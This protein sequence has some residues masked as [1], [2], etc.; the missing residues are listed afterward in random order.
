ML[1][2][3]GGLRPRVRLRLSMGKAHRIGFAYRLGYAQ[4]VGSLRSQMGY[5]HVLRYATPNK[6]ALYGASKLAGPFNLATLSSAHR[7]LKGP[8]K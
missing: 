5:A 6:R 4:A 1:R 8:E 7:L 2:I 3:S